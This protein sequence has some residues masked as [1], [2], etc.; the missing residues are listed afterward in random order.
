MAML[1]ISG[2]VNLCL[3]VIGL[4]VGLVYVNS[5]KPYWRVFPLSST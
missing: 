5:P 4:G 1:L 3:I 2:R